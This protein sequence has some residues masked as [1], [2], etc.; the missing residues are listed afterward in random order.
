ML[1]FMRTFNFLDFGS[2][3]Y[4]DK[5]STWCRVA[6]KLP[7]VAYGFELLLGLGL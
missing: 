4:D 6:G 5:S 2:T 7:N 1:D 3:L